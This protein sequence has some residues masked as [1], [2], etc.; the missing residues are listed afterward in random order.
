M[1]ILP[2]VYGYPSSSPRAHC[3]STKACLFCATPA[4]M[5]LH[6]QVHARRL[7]PSAVPWSSEDR[8]L[9]AVQCSVNADVAL[10]YAAREACLARAKRKSS[11][12]H[13]TGTRYIATVVMVVHA[14]KK[15]TTKKIYFS[16]APVRASFC[17]LIFSTVQTV[18]TELEGAAY[19]V[20]PFCLFLFLFL[21][22]FAD[23]RTPVLQV[24]N[25]DFCV[26][27]FYS[28][29]SLSLALSVSD[30]LSLCVC[31][32]VCFSLFVSVCLPVCLCLCLSV[33]LSLSHCLCPCLSVCLS[34]SCA[35]VC[36]CARVRLCVFGGVGC[37]CV[38]VC[39]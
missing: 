16:Q 33:S 20:H 8:L 10:N 15:P 35:R 38:C 31:V 39:W 22:S 17:N 3:I 9:P 12:I 2:F 19:L 32:S 4:G 23:I 5:D 37:S 21:R 18:L 29:P 7:L 36:V 14:G 13:T 25:N 26:I 6:I 34:L 11:G 28:A 1:P 30:S 27:H 24:S